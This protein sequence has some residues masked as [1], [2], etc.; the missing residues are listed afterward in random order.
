MYLSQ[1][2]VYDGI[3]LAELVRQKEVT[4]KEL[5]NAALEGIAKVNP[6]LNAIVSV[7]SE[8]ADEQIDAGL[9]DGPFRGVPFLI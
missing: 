8:K 2:S 7:L 1:Y 9:P 5:K 6:Q 4:P 3:G